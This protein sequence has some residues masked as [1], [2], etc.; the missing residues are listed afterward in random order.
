[1]KLTSVINFLKKFTQIIEKII[2]ITLIFMMSFV[3]LLATVELARFVISAIGNEGDWLI[4]LN[5]LTGLFGVFLLV[6]IGIELL[7]TIKVYLKQNVVHVE[8]VVLVAIIALARK[9]VII[10]VEQLSGELLIGIGVLIISLAIAYYLIKRTGLLTIK[11]KE[12]LW[13]EV[14]DEIAADGD[15]DEKSVTKSKGKTNNK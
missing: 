3:L 2:V 5:G 9:I 1:M 10:E 15:N 7:D 11:M 4:S 12:D 14:L 8:V 13:K 6:L